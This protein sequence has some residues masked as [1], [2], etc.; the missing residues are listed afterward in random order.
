MK[1][2]D[3]TIHMILVLRSVKVIDVMK[4]GTPKAILKTPPHHLAPF[5]AKTENQKIEIF[6]ADRR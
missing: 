4:V 2:S 3:K 5:D 1:I 6:L